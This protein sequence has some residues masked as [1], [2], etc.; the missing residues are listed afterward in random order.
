M[1]ENLA[2]GN[3]GV[4]IDLQSKVS[5]MTANGSDI[6]IEI[7][8]SENDVNSRNSGGSAQDFQSQQEKRADLKP[9][10]KGLVIDLVA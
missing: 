2:G 5:D 1:I 6:K 8:Q 10:G 3:K 9:E 4:H 7:T